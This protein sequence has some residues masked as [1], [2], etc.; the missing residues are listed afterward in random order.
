MSVDMNTPAESPVEG[1]TG[2]TRVVVTGRCRGL[3]DLC[4]ALAD[5]TEL[6]LPG[7][8]SDVHAAAGMLDGATPTVVLHGTTGDVLPGDEL[9]WLREHTDQPIILVTDGEPGALFEEALDAGVA[10]VLVLPQ[11][12]DRVAF[13]VQRALAKAQGPAVPDISPAPAVLG[14]RPARIMTVLGPKGGSGKTTV[15][16]NLAATLVHHHVKRTLLVD[17]D[18]QFGDAALVLGVEPEKT[19]YDL[20]VAPGELDAAKLAGYVVHHPAGFDLLP[21]PLR[22]EDAE[23]VTDDGVAALLS[24]AREEYDA[25]VVDTSSPFTGPTLAAIDVT[26]DLLLLVGLEVTS[27]KNARLALRTLDLISYPAERIRLVL[28]A[29]TPSRAMKR[30]E[31]QGALDAKVQFELPYDGD[32]PGAVSRSELPVLTGRSG[33]SGTIREMATALVEPRV[34]RKS[35][36]P[37]LRRAS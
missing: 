28:N 4:D 6:D 13:A 20:L 27:L 26:G 8:A 16:T 19:I 36:I 17:L 3:A 32:V 15:A 5:S 35:R 22:P 10:D 34:T 18:L 9:A 11:S 29:T 12:P 33:L 37:S 24:V 14:V 7:W 1:S 30:R 23:L 25:V 21:A 31:L 2:R